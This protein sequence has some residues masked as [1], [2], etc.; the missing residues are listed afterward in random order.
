MTGQFLHTISVQERG[1]VHC[2]IL[3]GEPLCSVASSGRNVAAQ[4]QRTPGHG[5]DRRSYWLVS[6]LVSMAVGGTTEIRLA[7]NGA[8]SKS[9]PHGWDGKRGKEPA[10]SRTCFSSSVQAKLRVP[11]PKIESGSLSERAR[12]SCLSRNCQRQVLSRWRVRDPCE[13]FVGFR[14]EEPLPGAWSWVRM[15]EP[16]CS[17]GNVP[18][19]ARKAF[20]RSWAPEVPTVVGARDLSASRFNLTTVGL[21]ADASLYLLHAHSTLRSKLERSVETVSNL[22]FTADCLVFRQ[23][24]LYQIWHGHWLIDNDGMPLHGRPGIVKSTILLSRN[25]H[26]Y[27]SEKTLDGPVHPP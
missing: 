18:N 16:L 3:V 27:Q 14:D 26:L 17:S 5:P 13:R 12:R 19:S 10:A 22:V 25:L 6:H 8:R 7:M 9:S 2:A 1:V 11:Q 24:D 21:A 15:V 4:R 23:A 20:L